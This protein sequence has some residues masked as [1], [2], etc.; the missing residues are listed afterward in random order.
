M[1][2]QLLASTFKGQFASRHLLLV[3]ASSP[4]EAHTGSSTGG[5]SEWQHIA[6]KLQ[7]VISSFLFFILF[8]LI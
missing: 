8:M 2:H 7:G 4:S 3:A 5:V 6:E 1:L